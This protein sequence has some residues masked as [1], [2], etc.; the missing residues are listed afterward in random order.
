MWTTTVESHRHEVREA[1]LT[2]VDRIVDEQGLL[3]L[4]M[5]QIADAAGIGRATLY[6]YFPD[7]EDV[8]SAWH[9][10]LVDRHLAELTTLRDGP[11]TAGERLRSVLSFWLQIAGRRH[12]P[13][14]QVASA[15]HRDGHVGEAERRLQ[16]LVAELIDEAAA[17]GVVRSD[18]PASELA[19]YCLHA[20][21]AGAELE[22][23]GR[24]RLLE[25]V[26]LSLHE[27]G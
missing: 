10:R 21:G 7:V 26:W 6:K 24:D 2:A 19:A 23:A 12:H 25:L 27:H 18:V 22:S 20:L 3:S 11:G 13:G 15:L 14:V 9:R 4:R 16:D 17:T 1:I 5:T 8:L